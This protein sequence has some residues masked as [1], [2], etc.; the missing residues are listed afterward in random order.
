MQY[1]LSKEEYDELVNG[2]VQRAL[3]AQDKLQKLCTTI[4]DTMPIKLKG[5]DVPSPWTCIHSHEGF[6]GEWY[7]D[8]CPV[9]EICPEPNKHWSK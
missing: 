3:M 2:K 5:C 6:R 7:C 1:V 8:Q 9:K 4:C